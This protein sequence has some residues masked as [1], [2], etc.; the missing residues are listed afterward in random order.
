MKIFY[1]L[2]KRTGT[3]VPGR[4][5]SCQKSL[6]LVY[7]EPVKVPFYGTCSGDPAP[8]S[9]GTGTVREGQSAERGGR[10]FRLTALAAVIDMGILGV[11]GLE[12]TERLCDSSCLVLSG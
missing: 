2:K 9:K 5:L 3:N 6:I 4:S 7:E 1:L 8:F 10:D 12:L 11:A